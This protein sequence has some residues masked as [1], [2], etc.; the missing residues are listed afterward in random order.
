M[1]FTLIQVLVT[2]RS[3]LTIITLEKNAE[4]ARYL[5]K[6]INFKEANEKNNQQ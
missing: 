2:K 4:T 5:S 6:C 3:S 1:F